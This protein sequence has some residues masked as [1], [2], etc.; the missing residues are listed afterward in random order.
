MNDS[1]ILNDMMCY[2]MPHVGVTSAHFAI[3]QDVQYPVVKG[4][5]LN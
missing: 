3:E 4:W 1:L 2:I 5:L